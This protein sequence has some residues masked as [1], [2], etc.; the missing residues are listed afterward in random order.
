MARELAAGGLDYAPE[1]SDREHKSADPGRRRSNSEWIIA[2]DGGGDEQ[3]AA[4]TDLRAYL[5]RAALFTLQ[6]SMHYV[7]HLRSSILSELAEDCAQEALTSILQRL[8]SFRGQSRFTTWAYAFAVN[9]ALVAA[10]R[11]RWISVS[12]DRILDGTEPLRW[13][14]RDEGSLPDPERHAQ[15]TEMLAVIRHG[16]EH[17]LTLKQQQVLRALVFEEIPLDEVVRH[18]GSNRNAVYKLVH[19][20]RRK[21]KAHLMNRGFNFKEI[22][23]VFAGSGA[24]SG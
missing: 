7:G 15:Q 2:L 10:R 23:E 5:L 4:L 1:R 22:L 12:V 24:A 6:R 3:A 21:L 9:T 8:G 17:E 14:A 18:C 11:E 13:R 19:D 16:I 20:A